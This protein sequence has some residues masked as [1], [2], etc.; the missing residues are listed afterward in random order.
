MLWVPGSPPGQAVCEGEGTR[1]EEGSKPSQCHPGYPLTSCWPGTIPEPTITPVPICSYLIEPAR[2]VY[3][4][5]TSLS[6]S[7]PTPPT[8]TGNRGTAIV[9]TQHH[10]STHK[11]LLYQAAHWPAMYHFI[12]HHIVHSSPLLFKRAVTEAHRAK[13]H[14]LSSWLESATLK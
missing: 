8:F 2:P 4:L 7:S 5:Q 1:L 11:H 10:C 13:W 12:L 6:S 9:L 3:H 14:A